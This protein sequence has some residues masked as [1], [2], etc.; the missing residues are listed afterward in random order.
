MLLFIAGTNVYLYQ[1]QKTANN[2]GTSNINVSVAI[3]DGWEKY[4]SSEKDYEFGY[5]ANWKVITEVPDAFMYVDMLNNLEGQEGVDWFNSEAGHN[6]W[7]NGK[8]FVSKTCRRPILQ[9]RDDASQLIAFDIYKTGDKT[10]SCFA[11]GNFFESNNWKVSDKDQ[12]STGSGE[13]ANFPDIEWK[14]DYRII[15]RISNTKD[16]LISI[17]LVNRETFTLKGES[18]FNQIVSTFK[19]TK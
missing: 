11:A 8:M 6:K 17:V 4:T 9:N 5:P 12:H 10:N 2:T 15:R 14:G 19:L 13:S 1:K 7:L 3:P 18:D 16:L